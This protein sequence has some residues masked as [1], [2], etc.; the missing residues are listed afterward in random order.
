MKGRST[1]PM[2]IGTVRVVRMTR[3]NFS[4]EIWYCYQFPPKNIVR[5]A[6][7]LDEVALLRYCIAVQVSESLR[8][9][10]AETDPPCCAAF[11][12]TESGNTERIVWVD[13]PY[14][15]ICV[16]RPDCWNHFFVL[17]HDPAVNFFHRIS[18][19]W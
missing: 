1:V 10:S 6:P 14:E 4:S 5:V 17:E 18:L 7:G 12:A 11:H 2:K 8:R 15:I 16:G 3:N 19:A 13:D 9:I